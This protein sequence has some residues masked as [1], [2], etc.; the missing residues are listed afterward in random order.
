MCADEVGEGG[1]VDGL[2]WGDDG[3]AAV[4]EWDP[5]LER[6]G[7]EGVG[8]VEE[9]AAGREGRPGGVGGEGGHGTVRGQDALRR[10]GGAGGV[11]Q[12]EAAGG[13][14]GAREWLVAVGGQ[15]RGCVGVVEV[16]ADCWVG[17]WVE[18]AGGDEDGGVAVG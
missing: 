13:G 5:D 17:W 15:S 6:G 16:D 11:H 12:V 2:G 7:V 10:S 4:E 14:G 9:D 8:G 3:G 18:V 1:G